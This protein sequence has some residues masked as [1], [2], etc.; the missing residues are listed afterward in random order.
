MHAVHGGDVGQ[1]DMTDDYRPEFTRALEVIARAFHE[2]VV[3]GAEMPVIV[4]GAAVEYHTVS[5]VQSADFD[6]VTAYGSDAILVE[7]LEKVGFKRSFSGSLRNLH[8]P[9]LLIGLDFVSGR[10]FEGKTDA[11]RIEIFKV[12]EEGRLEVRFPPVEDMIADRLG[13]YE[14][15]PGGRSDMLEQ[16]VALY[17]LA[18]DVDAEYLKRRVREECSTTA[19]LGLLERK[20]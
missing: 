16:A 12:D 7:E 2:A 9:D 13:Q 11:T 15:V 10:L 14:S 6:L 4:G 3:K 17:Q 19:L 8:H 20:S 1:L 18:G 5:E